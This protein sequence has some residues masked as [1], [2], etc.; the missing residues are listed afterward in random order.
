MRSL[1]TLVV[2]LVAIGISAPVSYAQ[3]AAKT[4]PDPSTVRDA[5]LEKDSL[6]NLEVARHYFK[7]KKA[8]VAAIKRCEEIDAGNPNFAKMDEVL[9]I[10]G[11]S[12]LRLAD[13][14][15]K[16]K[17][18]E[19]TADQLREDARM[20]LSRLVSGY[21]NSAFLKQAETDLQALGGPITPASSKP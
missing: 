19:K 2:L 17:T 9:F 20:Y 4:G 13:N 3:G 11:E 1:L 18:K 7:L 10:A 14:R 12:S 15:G 6:H 21:P 5:D 16:Q 8:Y